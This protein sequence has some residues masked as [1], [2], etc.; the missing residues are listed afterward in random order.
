MTV[1]S[2]YDVTSEFE[3]ANE[4]YAAGYDKADLPMPPGRKVFVLTCMDAR[5][6]PA[7]FLGLEEGDAHVYR[8]AGGRAAD[9]LRSLIVSQ[10]ALGTRRIVVIHHTDCGM[11]LI[12]EDEF[13][14]AVKKNTGEDVSH[15]S[16]LPIK[17][18][19]ESVRTDIDL[20][21][22]NPA[23]LDVPITGYIYDVKTGKIH[24]VDY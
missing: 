17:D 24:Q 21:R 12:K 22:K 2:E 5:L 8:N 15:I 19:E 7:K 4:Q 20:L 9:A 18:V 16:F 10:Q 23:V 14:D 13:R 11:L 1:D 6:D 3:L